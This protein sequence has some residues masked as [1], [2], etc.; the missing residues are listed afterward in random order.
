MS[1]AG[2][3]GS[4]LRVG[5]PPSAGWRGGRAQKSAWDAF[6]M[7]GLELRPFRRATPRFD[8]CAKSIDREGGGA[9]FG[10]SDPGREMASGEMVDLA[11]YCYFFFE[12]NGR[13]LSQLGRRSQIWLALGPNARNCKH[14]SPAGGAT[15]GPNALDRR[16][17]T[18]CSSVRSHRFIRWQPDVPRPSLPASGTFARASGGPPRPAWASFPRCGWQV[19]AAG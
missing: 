15:I 19:R 5:A 4:S 8:L 13:G 6:L 7:A 11:A 18:T 9:K 2:R 3:S 16:T 14:S 17:S 12:Q 1:R 10:A